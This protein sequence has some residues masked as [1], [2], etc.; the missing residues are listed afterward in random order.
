MVVLGIAIALYRRLKVE[1]LRRTTNSGDRFAIVLL[2]IIIFSGF[3]L[4]SVQILYSSIF[5]Q[6]A[7]DYSGAV[8]TEEIKPLKAYWEQEFG[9]VFPGA[10]HP[11]D[12]EY[13][14]KGRLLREESCAACHTRPKADFVSYPI[15]KAIRP[16][17]Y[18][19]RSGSTSG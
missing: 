18:S 4:E 10:V 7:K 16:A 6:M 5:D 3:L 12:P 8:E 1:D 15:A 14:K 2:A 19:T 11:T 9:V 17:G 13:L